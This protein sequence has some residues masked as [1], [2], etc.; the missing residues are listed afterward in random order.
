MEE[1]AHILQQAPTTIDPDRPIQD[2]GVD[3]LMAVELQTALESR[4]GVRLALTM[5]TGVSTLR[6]VSSS[7]LQTMQM[8]ASPGAGSPGTETA[9]A[10][11]IMRHEAEALTTAGT[12]A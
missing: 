3:S 5:L 1:V 9:I 6:V 8:A 4:L 12:G 10:E 7:L 11:T 2:L